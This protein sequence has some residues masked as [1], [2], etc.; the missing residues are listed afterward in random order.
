MKP[1]DRGASQPPWAAAQDNSTLHSRPPDNVPDIETEG[2]SPGLQSNEGCG[3]ASDAGMASPKENS[4]GTRK[5]CQ[6]ANDGHAP[7]RRSWQH[8][9]EVLL[10]V[11]AD[12]ERLPREPLREAVRRSQGTVFTL[13][14]ALEYLDDE[15]EPE[16]GETGVCGE[17]TPAPGSLA[18]GSGD[19]PP[20]DDPRKRVRALIVELYEPLRRYFARHGYGSESEDLAMEVVERALMRES[21]LF[22]LSDMS[23]KGFVWGI[24]HFVKWEAI[25]KKMSV[26]LWPHEQLVALSPE[27]RDIDEAMSVIHYGLGGELPRTPEALL[28]VR[29]EWDDFVATLSEHDR[30]VLSR[31]LAQFE[32]HENGEALPAMSGALRALIFRAKERVRGEFGARSLERGSE[33][34][35]SWR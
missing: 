26:G 5:N 17:Q 35:A 4:A 19:G 32:A 30:T 14:Q 23:V 24:A 28:L 25:G 21:R 15:E 1:Q 33:R 27:V 9:N 7:G 6:A 20:P 29:R 16:L 18:A 22:P 2:Y 10:E 8:L 34:P 3:D 31:R 11:E 13:R 12:P